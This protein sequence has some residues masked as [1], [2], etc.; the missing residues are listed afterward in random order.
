ML[1]RYGTV[2]PSGPDLSRRKKLIIKLIRPLYYAVVKVF[3]RQQNQF[4][5]FIEKPSLPE[6]LL[7]WLVF[8]NA[9]QKIDVDYKWIRLNYTKSKNRRKPI[10]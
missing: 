1:F 7:P 10:T 6:R 8:N 4:A 2:W 9:E 3:P 5:F